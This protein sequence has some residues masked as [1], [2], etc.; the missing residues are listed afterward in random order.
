MNKP[1]LASGL[2]FFAMSLHASEFMRFPE[3]DKAWSVDIHYASA[4]PVAPAPTSLVGQPDQAEAPPR[5]TRVDCAIR[6]GIERYRIQW[7]NK[8]TTEV[9]KHQG[10]ILAGNPVTGKIASLS[11]GLIPGCIH[12]LDAELFAWIREAGTGVETTYEKQQCLLYE[13]AATPG[14]LGASGNGEPARHRKA[15]INATTLLPLAYDN[16]QATFIFNFDT[17]LPGSLE[18]PADFAKRHARILG[19][20]SQPPPWAKKP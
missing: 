12:S 1:L 13:K 19:T 2:L 18:M 7:S 16:G 3:G 8:K 17:G 11:D 9:W 20:I 10:V 6:D 4:L 5:P 15:W 14:S